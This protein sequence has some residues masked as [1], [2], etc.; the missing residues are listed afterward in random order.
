MIKNYLLALLLALC[1]GGALCAA[2]VAPQ[3]TNR[4]PHHVT[5]IGEMTRWGIPLAPCAWC[6]ETNDVEVHHVYPQKPYPERS[7]DTNNMACLCR[8]NGTG[9]HWWHGHDG[10]NWTNAVTNLLQLIKKSRKKE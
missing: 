5:Q 3:P 8:T 10:K 4:A 6:G 1:V 2:T 9:C 7:H